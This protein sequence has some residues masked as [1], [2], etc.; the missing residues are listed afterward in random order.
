MKKISLKSMFVFVC[1][2][3]LIVTFGCSCSFFSKLAKVS[4][5]VE[6]T[7]ENSNVFDQKISV[8]T[9]IK[10]KFR[11]PIDT[12]CYKKVGDG[13]ELILDANEVYQCYDAVGNKF[14][15]ATYNREESVVITNAFPIPM[16]KANQERST[17]Y[18]SS[19]MDVPKKEYSLIY[20]IEIKNYNSKEV[21]Y[22]K[23]IEK[24]DVFGNSLNAE[25]IGQTVFFKVECD[26]YKLFDDD[27]VYFKL[28]K[29]ESAKVII[30]IKNLK[31]KELSEESEGVL[32]FVIPVVIK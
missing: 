6:V 24:E 22:V 26:D 12:P 20:E 7:L 18:Q 5:K 21:I 11:E 8:S 19:V 10:K 13:Y 3:S 30:E 25:S 2:F 31:E 14:E 4:Y 15:K 32:N 16:D 9:V 27:S 29:N 1:L 28:G 17:S 23:N